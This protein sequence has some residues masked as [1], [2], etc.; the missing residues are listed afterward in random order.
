MFLNKPN[1]LVCRYVTNKALAPSG[2]DLPDPDRKA[3]RGHATEQIP[4]NFKCVVQGL[5]WPVHVVHDVRSYQE[6]SHGVQLSVF[7]AHSLFFLKTCLHT[8][9]SQYRS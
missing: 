6:F 2:G 8:S 9:P 5:Q 7:S 3:I 1:V 4:T